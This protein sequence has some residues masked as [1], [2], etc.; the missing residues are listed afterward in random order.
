[1]CLKIRDG[2]SLVKQVIGV[3]CAASL[4]D[5]KWHHS[6]PRRDVDH[7]PTTPSAWL[8]SIGHIPNIAIVLK[9]GNVTLSG[10]KYKR[11][12]CARWSQFL[13]LMA[14]S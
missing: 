13:V 7:P 6:R 2:R 11:W 14:S 4:P 12:Y 3:Q 1:M 10:N 9:N 8:G 5:L